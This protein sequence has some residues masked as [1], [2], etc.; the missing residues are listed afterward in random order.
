MNTQQYND[1]LERQRVELD[2]IEHQVDDCE[3]QVVQLQ[4]RALD[5]KLQRR[6]D[7]LEQL[8]K[9]GLDSEREQREALERRYLTT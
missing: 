2:H 9:D 7:E 4:I 6:L 8:I 5:R 1:A 3:S